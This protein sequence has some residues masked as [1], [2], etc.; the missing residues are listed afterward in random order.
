MK[1]SE[2]FFDMQKITLQNN[3]VVG[4]TFLGF[5]LSKQFKCNFKHDHLTCPHRFWKGLDLTTT[6]LTSPN[7]LAFASD[8]GMISGSK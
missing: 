1:R 6:M 3:K 8:N 2:S 4:L 5:Q 7:A